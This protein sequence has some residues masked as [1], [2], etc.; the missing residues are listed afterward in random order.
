MFHGLYVVV[1]RTFSPQ[2]QA[3]RL[4]VV[5]LRM[6]RVNCAKIAELMGAH[7]RHLV[8]TIEGSTH[9]VDAALSYHFDHLLKM[10]CPFRDAIS[11]KIA[12]RGRESQFPVSRLS[13][14]PEYVLLP[15]WSELDR[16]RG[17]EGGDDHRLDPAPFPVDDGTPSPPV[18]DQHSWQWRTRNGWGEGTGG[19]RPGKCN[20]HWPPGPGRRAG[21][22]P[23]PLLDVA[24][25]SVDVAGGMGAWNGWQQPGLWCLGTHVET[26]AGNATGGRDRQPDARYER[27]QARHRTIGRH[28]GRLAHLMS[29]LT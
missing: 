28:C 15:A 25:Q 24:R 23:P 3:L 12:F 22:S 4:T 7:W 8:N 6:H 1:L 26:H 2:I 14:S 13:I 27:P 19:A 11:R 18:D 5:W 20:G 17:R 29:A 10:R 16:R 21:E 9:N